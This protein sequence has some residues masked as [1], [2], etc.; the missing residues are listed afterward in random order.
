MSE[1]IIF[2]SKFP[3]IDIVESNLPEYVLRQIGTYGSK[4]ALI[5]GITGE[6]LT[7]DDITSSVRK[8]RTLG[9]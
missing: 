2:K 3:S 6:S 5:D 8:V 9:R 1:D 4:K 7:F